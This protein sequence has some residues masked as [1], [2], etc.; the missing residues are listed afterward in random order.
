M[1]EF[2]HTPYIY[3]KLVKLIIA[4]FATNIVFRANY[5][6]VRPQNGPTFH[7]HA[8]QGFHIILGEAQPS[9]IHLP[10]YVGGNY[11]PIRTIW[12]STQ[13]NPFPWVLIQLKLPLLVNMQ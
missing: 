7:E 2:D 8:S 1:L 12:P 9:L 11:Y 13:H 5:M 4:S 3:K 6:F 10:T